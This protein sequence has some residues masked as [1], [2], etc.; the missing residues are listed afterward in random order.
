MLSSDAG[1]RRKCHGHRGI[2]VRLPRRPDAA[3]VARG[4]LSDLAPLLA[5]EVLDD[6][7]LI[8]TE[9]VTNSVR[10]SDGGT[11][12]SVDVE[13]TGDRVRIEVTD[14]GTGFTP[15]PRTPGQS[16]EGGWGLHL[17]D[18]LADRWGVSGEAGGTR[19][20]LEIDLRRTA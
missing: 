15:R 16:R 2:S 19:V 6:M 5:R 9:L 7:R 13:V 14:S 3:S 4:Q 12:V 17:V 18:R 10:H 20:W 11:Q 1:G 8:V